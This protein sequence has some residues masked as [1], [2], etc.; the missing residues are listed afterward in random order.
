MTVKYIDMQKFSLTP[1]GRYPK[2]GTDNGETFRKQFLE[3]AFRDPEIDKVIVNLDSVQDGYEYGS[4]F[5]EESFGGLVR[6]SGI[7][8][9]VVFRKLEIKTI[10]I[11]YIQ[12]IN[13]YIK[14]AAA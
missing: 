11:D 4:S 2:D 9:E 14:R 10:F 7:P 6:S 3:P 1:Y 12:E 8:A 5:L 13:E